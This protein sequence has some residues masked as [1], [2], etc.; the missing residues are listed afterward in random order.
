MLFAQHLPSALSKVA[1]RYL[2]KH[3]FVVLG[4]Y[5]FCATNDCCLLASRTLPVSRALLSLVG[6]VV[7][8]TSFYLFI[9]ANLF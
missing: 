9:F 7:A 1:T 5:L 3:V 2:R 6:V 4:D 8:Q